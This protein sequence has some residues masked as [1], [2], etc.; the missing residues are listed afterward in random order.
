[1]ETFRIVPLSA[2]LAAGIRASRKDDFGNEVIEQLATGHGPCRVSL[3]PF[4]VGVDKRLL[5][6][7]SPFSK[8]NAFN[9]PGPVFIHAAE[10]K[11]YQDVHRFPPEIKADKVNFPLTLVG[12]SLDQRMVYSRLVGKDDVDNLITEI[13]AAHPEVACLHARNAEACCF[14]CAIE[15]M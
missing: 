10:V 14:I 15:R 7:H 11:P 3:R 9:Q 8:L 5:F 6:A 13:F 12:Y 1:M 4:R 2:E